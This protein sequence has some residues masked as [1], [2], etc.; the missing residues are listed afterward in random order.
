MPDYLPGIARGSAYGS[1]AGTSTVRRLDGIDLTDPLDGSAWTSYIATSAQQI[2][3][4]AAGAGA[5]EGGFSNALV[6]V[7][8]DAGGNRLAGV[9]DALVTTDALT[10]ENLPEDEVPSS[11]FL[12]SRDLLTRS[13]DV[14]VQMGGPLQRDRTHAH[15]A[16]GYSQQQRD[17]YG[18]RTRLDETTP[19][20][21]GRLSFRLGPAETIAASV[22]FDWPSAD[23]LAPAQVSGLVT[24]EIADHLSRRTFGARVAWRRPLTDRL[25]LEANY[26]VLSGSRDLEPSSLVPGRLDEVTGGFTGSQGRVEDARRQRHVVSAHV[27]RDLVAAGRHVMQAGAEFEM[28]RIDETAGFVD[29]EFFI[30]FAGRP[31][32]VVEWAGD[33]LQGRS[34]RESLFVAD[35]WSP[36]SRLAVNLGVRADLLHGSTPGAGEVYSATT[37]QPRAGATLDVIGGART[38]VRAHYGVYADPLY[39]S[40]YDRAT[41]G[42]SPRVTYELLPNGTRREVER[43]P[44]PIYT[45]DSD[46]NHPSIVETLFGVDQQVLRGA[47]VGITGVFRNVR[48]VVDARFPDSRWIALSRPGLDNRPITVY[49]WANRVATQSNGVI[50]NVDGSEYLAVNGTALGTA[51]ARRHSRALVVHGRLDDDQQRWAVLAGVTFA[52]VTGTLDNTFESGIARSSQ[53]ESASAALVNV[54][55][56]A[57]QTPEREYTVLGTTRIPW[58]GARVSA[59]YIGQDGL[60]YHAVRQFGTE[61]LDFPISD[62]GRRVLLEARGAR[63]LDMDHRLDMRVELQPRLRKQSTHGVRRRDQPPQPCHGV[64]NRESLS[65]RIGRR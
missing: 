10:S 36:V 65:V 30:D 6:D 2:V 60:S 8:T 52:E 17:P 13:T 46:L 28:S 11:P 32:L 24:D 43:S 40:H 18:P 35:F 15:V 44:T 14:S 42:T 38:I 53:F 23:G 45:V 54:D 25:A 51:E 22:L 37:F 9:F 62:A 29:D 50:G 5:T 16:F 64:A 58:V 19:R 12:A 61:T 55:G 47:R 56:R 57:V 34:R 49:R 1:A 20:V 48:N 7:V 63:A 26:S 39:F 31:T 59:A 21:Q 27:S 33:D 41:P 4:H 3:E